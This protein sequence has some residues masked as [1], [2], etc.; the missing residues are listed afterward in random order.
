M[1]FRQIPPGMML[2][3]SHRPAVLA[4]TQPPNGG[5]RLETATETSIVY[6]IEELKQKVLER[7]PH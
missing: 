6:W 2:T 7:Q 4:V 3:G 1:W 5:K